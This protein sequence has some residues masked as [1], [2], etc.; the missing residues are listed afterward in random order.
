MNDVLIQKFWE[1]ITYGQHIQLALVLSIA[2]S[3]IVMKVIKDHIGELIGIHQFIIVSGL[4]VFITVGLSYLQGGSLLEALTNASSVA[5]Y[6]V[7]I[8]QAVKQIKKSKSDAEEIKKSNSPIPASSD[9]S[10]SVDH[11]IDDSRL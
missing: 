5:A 9:H 11:D 10:V 1:A 4:G 6:Q 8:H 7:F 3:T 2:I